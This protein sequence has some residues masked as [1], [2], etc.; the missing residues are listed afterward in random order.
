MAKR[1]Q[2]I[3]DDYLR[4]I[5]QGEIREGHPLPTE[6]VLIERYGVSRTA[7]REAIQKLTTMGFVLVRQGSG[8]TVAPRS[9]WNVLDGDYLAITGAGDGLLEHLLESRENL[10]PI[11]ASLAATRASREVTDRLVALVDE[12]AEAGAREVERHAELDVAFHHALAEGS[13]N[14]VL[15]SLH[16]SISHL[17]RESRLVLARVPSSVQRAVFWHG[18]ITDAVVRRDPTAAHDAMRMHLRQVHADLA[19][20]R[21]PAG[22]G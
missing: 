19:S 18:Q 2:V 11:I 5:A 21:R 10:E 22:A 15:V 1:A 12:L 3:V 9:A 17:D 8:S 6:S 13:G 14:P 20:V 7:V 4:Q 16:G